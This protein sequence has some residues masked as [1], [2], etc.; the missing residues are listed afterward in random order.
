VEE[1]FLS[2]KW[3]GGGN[4]SQFEEVPWRGPRR[5]SFT[6]DLGRYVKKVS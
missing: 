2:L 3:L 5:S 6:G 4:V 1:V